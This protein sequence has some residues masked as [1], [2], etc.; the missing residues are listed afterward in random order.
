MVTAREAW[1]TAAQRLEQAGVE[2]AAFDAAQLIRFVTG[3]DAYLFRT[4]SQELQVIP[5]LCFNDAS[6]NNAALQALKVARLPIPPSLR[7]IS[8]IS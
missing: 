6:R 5:Y 8:N 4:T 3:A 2:D 1:R 7:H